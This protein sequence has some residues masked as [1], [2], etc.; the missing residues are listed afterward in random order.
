MKNTS[1]QYLNSEA[2]GYLMEAKACKL[3]LKDLERIRAKLKRHIEKEAADREAEFEAAM[4]YHSESDIQEAYGWEFISEQ[5]YERYLEL[6]RQG[7]KALDEHSP[8]VTELALSILNRIFQDIDRDCSQ[9]EFEAL[10]PEEQLAELKCAEESRQAW[11]QYIASLKEMVGSMTGKTNDHTAS[12]KC[13]NYTQGGC[14]MKIREDRSH[15]NIDTRWFEKGY[16]K[17]DVHSLRLQSLCTEAEAAANKQFYDSH[18]REEWEQY[19]RQASL[20]SSAAMKPVMEAI[21]QDFVCYQYDENIPVSYGSDRW[22][23]Y[24]WCNP[25]NGAADASE[26]DFSYFTLTFNERQTLE[27]R[28]KVCQQVLD[29]LCSRFQEHPNLDVAVQYS[30]W[31]DHPKIHDAVE[32][33]K[34]RLHGLRCIQDQKE[35]KLLLQ[36]GALLF[37]PKYAKKYTRTLSQSQILSLSWELGVEDG[38]PD[39]DAAP[40]TL[41]YK[42]FG[43]THPIQLQVTSYLNGNLAIQ[44]VTWESGD[45]EP[46][47]TLTVNLPGQRQKDHAFIDTNADSEFP[48]WLIRHG[49]AIPT[50]RTMQSGFCTYPEYRFRANRLQ[51]LDPEGY[52][53]Y[54]KNFERR[55]SA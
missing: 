17:E 32:R 26:R 19:I 16:A 13:S 5:Q 38:E 27:K 34:P 35:G 52:A 37:K 14:K 23:L 55:C 53:G 24:F 39:T 15:M 3:L 44:M 29:L 46:W 6:F 31:F 28:R 49:L 20:E 30:I 22:D 47:A 4:Q 54:L 10:S 33:A 48:T 21:A 25:F 45:P 12:K 51:E 9:C 50:G 43:A 7:R 36:D 11:K 2:H 8:T 42:K 1:Q 18:T 40:V 41:P